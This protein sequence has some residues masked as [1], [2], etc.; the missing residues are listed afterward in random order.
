VSTS[1]V[2]FAYNYD[3]DDDDDDNKPVWP[4]DRAV[5]A[6]FRR[7]ETYPHRSRM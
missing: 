3:A 5:G 6:L 2:P 1:I 7:C 4:L